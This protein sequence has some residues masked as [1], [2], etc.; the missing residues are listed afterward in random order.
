MNGANGEMRIAKIWP[1]E[2]LHS[3]LGLVVTTVGHG[4]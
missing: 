1:L 2:K 3:R 4:I